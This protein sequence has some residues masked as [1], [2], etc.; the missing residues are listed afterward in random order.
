MNATSVSLQTPEPELTQAQEQFRKAFSNP[1]AS[2]QERAA[3]V[4]AL[5]EITDKNNDGKWNAAE[6]QEFEKLA[7][8]TGVDFEKARETYKADVAEA[9]EDIAAA[10]KSGNENLVEMAA[11]RHAAIMDVNN[12]GKLDDRFA[13]LIQDKGL[14]DIV[15]QAVGDL[16]NSMNAEHVVTNAGPS[17][18]PSGPARTNEVGLA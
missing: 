6:R 16:K 12:D 7:R 5:G 17:A 4:Q 18:T 15:Q 2:E 8:E 13:Q 14:K 3:A 10:A 11:S 1:N 9:K